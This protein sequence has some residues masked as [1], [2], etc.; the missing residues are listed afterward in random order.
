MNS[1]E[2]NT[3]LSDMVTT[4]R[5]RFG[6]SVETAIA[7]VMQSKTANSLQKGINS[8]RNIDLLIDSLIKE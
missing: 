1:E 5:K 2:L 8:E 7:L 6:L 3:L 4:L